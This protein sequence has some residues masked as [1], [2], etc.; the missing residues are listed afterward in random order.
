MIELQI[1]L[2]GAF[3]ACTNGET[4][5]LSVP[6]ATTVAT[7]RGLL[8]RELGRLYPAF[9]AALV[10]DSAFADDRRNLDEKTVLSDSMNIAILPPVC[11]G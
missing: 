1:R 4:L 8:E 7:L 3:R 6:E 2:F 11:G 5:S 9:N 10:A